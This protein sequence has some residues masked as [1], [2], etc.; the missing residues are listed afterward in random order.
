MQYLNSGEL[1]QRDNFKSFLLNFLK[2]Q[3]AI[4]I[5]F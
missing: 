2:T 3:L 4:V 5:K 1:Q